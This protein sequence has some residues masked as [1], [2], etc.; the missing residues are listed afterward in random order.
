MSR[1]A[2]IWISVSAILVGGAIGGYIWWQNREEDGEEQD[3]SL[4]NDDWGLNTSTGTSTGGLTGGAGTGASSDS[5]SMTDK[6][7]FNAVKNFFGSAAKVF[8]NRIS[9]TKTEGGQTVTFFFYSNGRFS[10]TVNEYN[11]V[12]KG[13]YYNGG[14]RLVVTEA[15]GKW[16]GNKG[17]IASNS[18]P[19]VNMKKVLQ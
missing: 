12:V 9:V 18:S 17:L 6:Q 15:K 3:P 14:K 19:L 7:N 11:A 2:I 5:S 16:A 10:V 1:K 4:G 8:L 13:N